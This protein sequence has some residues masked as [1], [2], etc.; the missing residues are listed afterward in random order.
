MR[1]NLLALGLALTLLATPSARAET[2]K[3]STAPTAKPT[4]TAA[5]SKPPAGGESAKVVGAFMDSWFKGDLEETMSY[6]AEDVYYWNVPMEPIKGRAKS[7]QF[8]A[9]FFEKD[10]LVVPSTFETHIKQTLADGANVI[11]ERVDSFD[12][13]GRKWKIPVIAVFEVKNG[14]ISVWKDYFDMAQFQPVATL[15][16]VLAKKK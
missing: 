7:R 9:P 15:I 12:I 8:L 13:N 5:E 6:L 4:R 3:H 1:T 11:V 16:D 2:K 10:P 14:K